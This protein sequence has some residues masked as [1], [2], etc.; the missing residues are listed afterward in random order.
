MFQTKLQTIGRS[1]VLRIGVISD[2]H[3]LLRPEAEQRLAGVDH[4]IH[5]GDIGRP[6]VIGRLREIAPVIAI[7]GNVDKGRWAQ[8]HPETETVRLGD[9]AI[10]ILHDIHDLQFDPASRGISVVISGHS[11]EPL[12]ETRGG[13]LYLNPGSAGPRRFNLPITLATLDLTTSGPRAL[14]HR[15]VGNG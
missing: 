5:A 2:T 9:H 3:G 4:I 1:I 7:K 15:L 8:L 12:I 13:V 6:E 10:H 14:L 11:H